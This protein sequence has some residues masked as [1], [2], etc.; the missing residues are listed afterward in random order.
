LGNRLIGIASA[1]ADVSDGLLADAGHIAAASRLEVH[2]VRELVPLSRAA[3]C[4]LAVDPALWA[5]VMGGGD[6]YELVIA[7]S[8]RKRAALLAAACG[9]DV[10][11]TPIGRFARGGGVRLTVDGK[12]VKVPRAGYVHF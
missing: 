11:V 5:N 7:V 12:G 10:P 9:A 6:D 2:I 1:V 3:R 8:P 4:A